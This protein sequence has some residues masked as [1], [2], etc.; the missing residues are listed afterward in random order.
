MGGVIL[1]Y[2]EQDDFLAHYGVKGM[3]WG[4]RKDRSGK[5]KGNVVTKTVNSKVTKHKSNLVAKYKK[6]GMTDSEAQAAMEKRVKAEKYIATAAGTALL[7]Y[8]GY[9]VGRSLGKEYLDKTIRAGTELHTITVEPER[10]NMSRF[11]ATYSPRDRFIYRNLY[12]RQLGDKGKDVYDVSRRVTK[13]LKAPSRKKASEIFAELYKNDSEF[14][15]NIDRY[16]GRTA[17]SAFGTNNFAI[18]AK[19]AGEAIKRGFTDKELKSFGYDIFNAQLANGDPTNNRFYDRLKELGYNAV[20]DVNDRRYSNFRTNNSVII[21]DMGSVVRSGVEQLDLD[22][23]RS[24]VKLE[25][26]VRNGDKYVNKAL[27]GTVAVGAYGYVAKKA[28]EKKQEQQERKK[29]EGESKNDNKR[30]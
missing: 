22:R 5:S 6:K 12:G 3:K 2:V 11:Y 17:S 13:N 24:N 29:K 8:A 4:V 19:R 10:T 18:D 20:M 7:A 27:A 16:Y 28:D 25:D 15:N 14:R 1:Y 23:V 9:K 21:F 30:K 26:F